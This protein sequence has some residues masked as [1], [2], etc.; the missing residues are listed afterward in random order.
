[1]MTVYQRTVRLSI[2]KVH[3]AHAEPRESNLSIGYE[4]Q[5][6]NNREALP[7]TTD[8]GRRPTSN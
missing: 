3:P 7:V 1:M 6:Y 5:R 4:G 2:S 8:I